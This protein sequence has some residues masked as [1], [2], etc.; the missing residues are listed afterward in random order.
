M[1]Q[2]ILLQLLR[3]NLQNLQPTLFRRQPYLNVYLKP[4][5]PQYRLINQVLSVCHPNHQNVIQRL[6]TINVR[7]QLIHHLVADLRTSI[8]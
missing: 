4:S 8:R 6:H 1:Q 5:R 3:V 7:Q 2:P